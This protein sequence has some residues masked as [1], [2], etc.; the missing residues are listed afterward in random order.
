MTIRADGLPA[1]E[2]LSR[3]QQKMLA[4]ALWLSQVQRFIE[5]TGQRPVLLVDDLAAELDGD[6]LNRFLD[7]LA[8]QSTQQILTAISDAE[9][10]RTGLTGGKVFHVEQGKILPQS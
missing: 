9:M 4:G 7:L 5:L 2:R 3:G 6:R 10:V 1:E 8:R